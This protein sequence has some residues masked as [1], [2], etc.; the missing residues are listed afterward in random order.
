MAK[1]GCTR[2]SR[3]AASALLWTRRLRY[4]TR[5]S[6]K[7]KRL[8]VARPSNQWSTR[9][10]P[11]SSFAGVTRIRAPVSQAGSSPS[12]GSESTATS[13]SW[14][15]KPSRRSVPFACD[16]AVLMVKTVPSILD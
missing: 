12:T 4:D 5:P 8:S 3:A 15:V 9:R 10:S 1:P 11:T 7:P 2:P 16:I 13:S 14:L 6:P